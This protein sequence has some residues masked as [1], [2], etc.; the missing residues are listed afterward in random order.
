VGNG[1]VFVV[2]GCGEMEGDSGE[3]EE[4]C[5]VEYQGL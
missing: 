1:V 3:D 2:A 5:C 4:Y